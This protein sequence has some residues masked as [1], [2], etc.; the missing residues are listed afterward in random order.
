MRI[1]SKFFFGYTFIYLF[2]ISACGATPG[3]QIV[4]APS[5]TD[6]LYPEMVS[7]RARA[8]K[9]DPQEQFILA[10]MFERGMGAPQN[11]SEA[12]KWYRLAAE[13]G[14]APAQF[15]LAAMY[16]SSRGV[17]Q[18]FDLA[19]AWFQ[20]SADQGYKDAFYPMAFANENGIGTEKNQAEALRWYKKS[21]EAGVW[22]AMD[23]IAKAY[24]NGQLGLAVDLDK[25]KEWQEKANVARG[26]KQLVTVPIT[27]R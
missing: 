23:R 24:L 8:Q 7:Q 26:D 16:G 4:R 9:G 27:Q 18:N 10:G 17:E 3:E 11:Y 2:L 21:A 19:V 12:A 25:A 6:S 5:F 20:K 22:H 13:Q 15:F 1:V 14:H